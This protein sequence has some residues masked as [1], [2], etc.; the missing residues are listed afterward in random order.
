MSGLADI[1]A[2]FQAI[3]GIGEEFA[4]DPRVLQSAFKSLN[5]YMSNPKMM[6]ALDKVGVSGKNAAELLL[7]M[8][9][10]LER[11]KTALDRA[12]L[13]DEVLAIAQ[14]MVGNGDRINKMGVAVDNA[15]GDVTGFAA[16]VAEHAKDP[17]VAW[18]GTMERLKQAMQPL[19]TGVLDWVVG[20]REEIVGAFQTFIDKLREVANWLK[21][22]WPAAIAAA[23]AGKAIPAAA[24]LAGGGASGAALALPMIAAGAGLFDL[25]S[26]TWNA[27]SEGRLPQSGVASLMEERYLRPMRLEG[28]A[29]QGLGVIAGQASAMSAER[30][31]ADAAREASMGAWAPHMPAIQQ[32]QQA[33]SGELFV[34][35]SRLLGG[36]GQRVS[37][38]IKISTTENISAEAD[39][40]VNDRAVAAVP[41]P[42]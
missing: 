39:V 23:L 33:A 10:L 6:G 28:G 19:I 35:L 8:S 41:V 30:L 12:G 37:G 2:F 31:R 9:Q 34:M 24:A 18:A 40:R 27:S 32:A 22:W 29:A 21:E 38:A 1:S 3:A 25:V 11:D 36:N 16:R 4:G 26:E 15:A 17:E 5:R 13:P 7:S 20:H 14:A 42:A